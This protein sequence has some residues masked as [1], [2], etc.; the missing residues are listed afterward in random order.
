[1]IRFKFQEHR[2]EN[3]LNPLPVAKNKKVTE[4]LDL[5]E[6]ITDLSCD[7]SMSVA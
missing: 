5:I 4:G 7:R 6:R 1:M 2:A 3:S